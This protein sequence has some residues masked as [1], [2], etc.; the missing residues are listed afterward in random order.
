MRSLANR[1]LLVASASLLGLSSFNAGP[2]FAASSGATSSM[3]AAGA[4]ASCG[5]ATSVVAPRSGVLETSA[6]EVAMANALSTSVDNPVLLHAEAR[7]S[8]WLTSVTCKIHPG[9][10][11][12]VPSKGTAKSADNGNPTTPNW[13]GYIAPTDSPDN[14]EGV[15]DVPTVSIPNGTASA[16]SSVWTG[17]GGLG[18]TGSSSSAGEL[19]QDGTEQNSLCAA[20]VHGACSGPETEYYAWYEQYPGENQ[21]E[22]SNMTISPGD[23]IWAAP[24]TGDTTT[25]A[26]FILCDDTTNV[27]LDTSQSLVAAPGDSSEWVVERSEVGGEYPPLADFGTVTFQDFSETWFNGGSATTPEAAF[28][29]PFDMYNSDDSTTL[30]STGAL[31]ASGQG[32][33]VTF[34]AAE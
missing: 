28:A 23:E 5:A 32:F 16:Y 29:E 2:A 27:C 12:T 13:A 20:V 21:V 24:G 33:T 17:V 10:R 19:V 26:Y 9:T 34:D 15:W 22:I 31:D 25:T 4:P 3:L 14:T 6:D 1:C 7:H 11:P 30:A 18:Y 8:R